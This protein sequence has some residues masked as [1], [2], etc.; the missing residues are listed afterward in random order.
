[1]KLHISDTL[2]LPPEEVG[3]TDEDV[4]LAIRVMSWSGKPT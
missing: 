2:A 3:L 1:V 4:E